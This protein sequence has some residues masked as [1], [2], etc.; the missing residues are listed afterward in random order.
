MDTEI[1]VVAI[2]REINRFR[3]EIIEKIKEGDTSYLPNASPKEIEAYADPSSEQ[4]IRGVYA[5]NHIYP[6]N[7]IELPSKV[8]MLKLNIF[9]EEDIEDLKDKEP[10]I[11]DTIIDKVFHDTTGL[12]I[13]YK[14]DNEIKKL[15]D[16]DKWWNDLP[17]K[18]KAKYK[19]LGLEAWNEFVDTYDGEGEVDVETKV[20][21]MQVLAIPQTEKIPEWV[22]P[23]IDYTTIVDNIL[24]PF[25]PVL[26]I[27]KSKQITVG[28]S[29]GGVNRKTEGF[30]NIIKI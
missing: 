14:K 9:K 13:T 28:K 23:Y 25:M 7:M 21:G 20:R 2:V 27:F 24:S 1:D 12:F 5:W 19:K 4:S 29:I 26:E 18:Y 15:K 3:E 17:K 10:E 30:S 6:N 8:S 22:L 11:Y 16:K